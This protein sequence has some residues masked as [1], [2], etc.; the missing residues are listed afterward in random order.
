MTE[1]RR[2]VSG[3]SA[4]AVLIALTLVLLLQRDALPW[5]I[6]F[7]DGWAVPLTPWLNA[8]MNWVI[9][10]FGIYFRAFSDQLSVL[11]RW[12]RDGINSLPWAAIVALVAFMAYAV[13]GWKLAVF[14]F[15]AMFYM[16]LIGFWTEAMNSLALVALSVP[17]AVIIGFF[18]GA[19]G[20]ASDRADRIIR[21]TMDMMQTIPA[22]AYLLPILLLFG[23]GPV[24]GLIASLLYAVPPMVRNTTM[25][26]GAVN[27]EVIEAG[28]MSGATRRQLFWRVRVPSAMRQILL[29]VN[30]TTMAAFSMVIIASI[31]GG[32]A[33]IGWEVLKS[34][35]RAEFGESL[36]LGLVIAFMAMVMDRLTAQIARRDTSG[37][38]ALEWARPRVLW[39]SA[40]VLAIAITAL[41][42]VL[43]FLKTYPAAWEFYP[44]GRLNSAVQYIVTEFTV[45]INYIKQVAFFFV[46][47]PV[48]MGLEKT[49]TPFSW[50]FAFTDTLKIGY[51]VAVLALAALSW[52]R[53]SWRAAAL[54]IFFGM[55]LFV[56]ITGMPWPALIAMATLLA[57]QTGGRRLALGMLAGLGFLL[58]AGVWEEAMLS[59]YLCGL[60]VLFCFLIGGALGVLA[61]E[62][63]SVSAALRPFNDTL[64]T[65]PLFVILI[66]F[67]MIF[68]IGEFTA[69][70]AIIAYA[71]VPSIRYT[72]HGIRSVSKEVIEAAT[73]SGCTPLQLLWRVKLPLAAP[74]I[75]L[76]L[77]QTIMYAIAMLVIAALVGTSDLGQLVYIGLGDGDFGVGIVAGVGMAIIAMLAD[78]MTQAMGGRPK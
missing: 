62:F 22:F 42:Q 49:I 32:T 56:G 53:R 75:L 38:E 25:G 52:Q 17:M 35:R 65:M 15:A 48:K 58:L 51:A 60:A 13:S 1:I 3:G 7:P 46:M 76:G 30:Q 54:V 4:W 29:G 36:L 45:T 40:L 34:I 41:A 50:G 11:M 24:V 2:W 5:A 21:P 33:D 77:N 9:D 10:S 20:F 70:L 71:I 59:I 39:L 28:S 57:Y 27:S 66:P 73:A 74:V 8:G 43:P 68:K 67:V 61:A 19:L 16:V 63:D 31:I 55:L 12:I 23:F 44:A 14:S 18:T 64:Q 37:P 78:R 69:L 26:L 6:R 47:L 72:E